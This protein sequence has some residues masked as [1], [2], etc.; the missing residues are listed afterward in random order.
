MFLLSRSDGVAVDQFIFIFGLQQAQHTERVSFFYGT[1]S[2]TAQRWS[3]SQINSVYSY[4]FLPPEY[5]LDF[6]SNCK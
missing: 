2:I 3:A 5:E 6:S 4:V 1:S